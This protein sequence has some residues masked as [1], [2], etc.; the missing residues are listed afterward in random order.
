MTVPPEVQTPKVLATLKK[1]YEKK[2]VH[3]QQFTAGSPASS[4]NPATHLPE[5]NFMSSFL[6]AALGIAGSIAMPELAPGLLGSGALAGAVGGGVGTT[7]GGLLSGQTPMQAGLSGLGSGAGGYMMGNLGN[8][9][10]GMGNTPGAAAG[11]TAASQIGPPMSAMSSL[12]NLY[13]TLPQG[14]NLTGAAGSALGGYL[15]GK[16]GAPAKTTGPQLPPGFNNPLQSASSLPSFQQQLGY[17]TYNG[18]TPNFS[19]YNPQTNNP[20][21][22]NFYNQAKPQS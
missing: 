13:G 21:A 9:L 4:V 17:N 16:L 3:P 14:M 10:T 7:A 11:S 20:G 19:G 18:P 6:P 12:N 8:G 2:G 22:W 15:G 5:Y 1:A